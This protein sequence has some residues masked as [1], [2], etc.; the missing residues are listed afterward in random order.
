[1]GW[2]S[3]LSY[4]IILLLVTFFFPL[5]SMLI[6]YYAILQVARTKCKRINVGKRQLESMKLAFRSRKWR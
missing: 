1:L 6:C 2:T 3:S 4:S 5:I